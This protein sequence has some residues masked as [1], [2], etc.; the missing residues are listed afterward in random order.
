MIA[1]SSVV[2]PAPLGPISAVIRP[3][4]N[5]AAHF[6]EDDIFM[7]ADADPFDGNGCGLVYYRVFQNGLLSEIFFSW[8]PGW[9]FIT[10]S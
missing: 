4:R 8:L 2:L 5:I 6:L 7:E 3:G 9:L 10:R 1:R